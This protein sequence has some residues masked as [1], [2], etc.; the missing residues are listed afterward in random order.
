M[1]ARGGEL[2]AHDLV[3]GRTYSADFEFRTRDGG[4][5]WIDA[6]HLVGHA[7]RSEAASQETGVGRATDVD[8]WVWEPG[9]APELVNL[10]EY[11][12][13]PYLGYAWPYGGTDLLVLPEGPR[14][15]ETPRL[16]EVG[17]EGP[18][19][20]PFEVPVLCDVVGVAGSELVLGHERPEQSSGD[21][22]GPEHANGAVVALD[23]ADAA[24]EDRA[25][26]QV[27]VT[28][29]A[30]HRVAFAT[31]LIAEALD[32]EGGAS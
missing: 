10:G 14:L 8:G 21:A 15:C 16:Q 32:A 1:S 30:P 29:G 3:S 31:D 28:A 4:H 20:A 2:V 19:T 27:V 24:F 26:R 23:V 18:Q 17:A 9:T 22:N 25:R 11:P 12:G 13:Q 5:F 6:T 7:L